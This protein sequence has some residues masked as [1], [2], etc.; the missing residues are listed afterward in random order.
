MNTIKERQPAHKTLIFE[1]TVANINLV[2]TVANGKSGAT[3]KYFTILPGGTGLQGKL[4][5]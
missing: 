5:F 3:V 4:N 2:C 1:C